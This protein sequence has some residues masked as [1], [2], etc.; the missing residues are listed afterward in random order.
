MSVN[1]EWMSSAAC[2]GVDPEVWFPASVGVAGQRETEVAA[3]I[4]R[5]CEVL[6]QC[7]A[8]AKTHAHGWG[9]WAGKNRASRSTRVPSEINHGTEAGAKQHHRRGEPPCLSCRNAATLANALRKDR[10]RSA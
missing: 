10:R 7:A 4:C 1:V 2:R 3:R 9:V 8:Y 6:D 5:G